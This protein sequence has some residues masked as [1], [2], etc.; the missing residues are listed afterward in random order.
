MVTYSDCMVTGQTDNRVAERVLSELSRR[1]ISV[2]AL[3][4]ATGIP[5]STLNR[6]LFGK[7]SF[8]VNELDEIADFFGTT[9]E[10]LIYEVAA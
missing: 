6:R 10:V 2:A 7:A 1:G 5:R 4:E 9:T 8:R 3:A